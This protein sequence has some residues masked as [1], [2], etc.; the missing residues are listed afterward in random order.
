[1]ASNPDY[2][3]RN[4]IAQL[5]AELAAMQRKIDRLTPLL[6]LQVDPASGGGQVTVSG[7]TAV[8]RINSLTASSAR[9]P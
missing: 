8:L 6:D 1:M 3:A 7:P 4:Q 5:R 2:E 9:L